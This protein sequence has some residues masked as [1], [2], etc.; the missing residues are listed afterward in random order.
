MEIK[1]PASSNAG[2]STSTGKKADTAQNVAPEKVSA[3]QNVGESS[4]VTVTDSALKLLQIENALAEM[5]SFD[6]EKVESI[7]QALS[8][9]SYTINTDSIA[10]KLIS[11][12]QDLV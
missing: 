6:A 2:L 1:Q 11:F 7:K 3:T 5:P 10:E 9:G 12:E 8:D 4:T